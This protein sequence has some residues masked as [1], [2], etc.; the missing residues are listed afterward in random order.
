[1]GRKLEII[2]PVIN[3]IYTNAGIGFIPFITP[4][5]IYEQI[6]GNLDLIQ[7]DTVLIIGAQITTSSLVSKR[8]SLSDTGCFCYACGL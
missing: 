2:K 4:K 3:I 8:T 6:L 1:V 7:D 5:E